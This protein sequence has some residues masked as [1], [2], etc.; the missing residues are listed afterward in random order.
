[1]KKYIQK[2]RNSDPDTKR[3]AAV[4]ISFWITLIIIALWIVIESIL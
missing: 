3:V 1:M 2:L 4:T